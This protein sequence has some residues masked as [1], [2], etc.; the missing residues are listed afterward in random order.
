MFLVVCSVFY[1]ALV[2][3]VGAD[4]IQSWYP[5]LCQR[6]KAEIAE[7]LH[8]FIRVLDDVD[9]KGARGRRRA[10]HR[11]AG[12][13]TILQRLPQSAP[14]DQEESRA[15]TKIK[16]TKA[17][18]DRLQEAGYTVQNVASARVGEDGKSCPIILRRRWLSAEERQV[19]ASMRQSN[20]MDGGLPPTHAPTLA[21]QIHSIMRSLHGRYTE[22]DAASPTYKGG[23]LVN[24]LWFFQKEAQRDRVPVS[25]SDD[26]P[27]PDGVA[28]L[29]PPPVRITIERER[30]ERGQE[31]QEQPLR[32]CART[33]PARQCRRRP[34]CARIHSSAPAAIQSRRLR[35]RRPCR[36][37][38]PRCS[39]ASVVP[40]SDRD[41]PRCVSLHQR[42]HG[43]R[44]G[45]VGGS[46]RLQPDVD[47]VGCVRS[48]VRIGAHLAVQRVAPTPPATP[49]R[50]ERSA[51]TA[52]PSAAFVYD[53]FA[54][55]QRQQSVSY[56]SSS[57]PPPFASSQASVGPG[58]RRVPTASAPRAPRRA[59]PSRPARPPGSTPA[60]GSSTARAPPPAASRASPASRATASRSSGATST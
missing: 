35:G 53:G 55:R 60:A 26:D 22:S 18:V 5:T 12:R 36:C 57:M 17:L 25:V 41:Q 2:L 42:R 54:N 9:C 58:P 14:P 46:G 7:D 28:P 31:K 6:L 32:C 37:E 48:R 13:G 50:R 56:G 19:S 38:C 33:R 1:R 47:R 43:G 52:P 16:G 51:P 4:P 15:W 49:A 40:P 10:A 3:A 29:R 44:G 8:G 34:R 45:R 21:S 27:M 39:A 20:I 24:L 11:T 23:A 59:S 30:R